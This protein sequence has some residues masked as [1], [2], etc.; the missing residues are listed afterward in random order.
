MQSNTPDYLDDG[1][2]AASL[3]ARRILSAVH[4]PDHGKPVA[5]I[6]AVGIVDNTA[7]TREGTRMNYRCPTCISKRSSQTSRF[8][9]IIVHESKSRTLEQCGKDAAEMFLDVHAKCL[10]IEHAD[11]QAALVKPLISNMSEQAAK[12][13]RDRELASIAIGDIEKSRKEVLE[14]GAVTAFHAIICTSVYGRLLL[15][16]GSHQIKST[17]HMQHSSS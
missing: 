3:E 8:K 17:I 15:R 6:A 12:K 2:N 7:S 14:K 1:H 11:W 10:G 16:S 9:P 4:S 5:A 13:T